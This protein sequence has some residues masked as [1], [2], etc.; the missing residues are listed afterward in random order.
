MD[1]LGIKIVREGS[2]KLYKKFICNKK[3][4][5]IKVYLKN[6]KLIKILHPSS[7]KIKTFT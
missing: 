3:Q 5:K 7:M 2:L 1:H 4:K 6:K